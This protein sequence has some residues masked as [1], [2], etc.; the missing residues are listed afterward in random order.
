M[1]RRR[2]KPRQ[3]TWSHR[4]RR[5]LNIHTS[6]ACGVDISA[7]GERAEGDRERW[8]V[9]RYSIVER[10]EWRECSGCCDKS[11]VSTDAMTAP[12][13]STIFLRANN[14][15]LSHSRQHDHTA[16][17]LFMG[18]CMSVCTKTRRFSRSLKK[19]WWIWHYWPKYDLLQL[20][21][22]VGFLA[23]EVTKW[24]SKCRESIG[25]CHCYDS[26]FNLCRMSHLFGVV[27]NITKMRCSRR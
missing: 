10:R 13:S 20:T 18:P 15:C 21:M 12:Q 1:G 4:Q 23:T 9:E 17:T 19:L 26:I 16:R 14:Y 22:S 6:D 7:R 3:V 2:T 11:P 27:F 25:S 5:L 24:R 8:R